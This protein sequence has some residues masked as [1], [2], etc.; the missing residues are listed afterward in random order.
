MGSTSASIDLRRTQKAKKRVRTFS[1]QQCHLGSALIRHF[2]SPQRTYEAHFSYDRMHSVPGVLNWPAHW[3]RQPMPDQAPKSGPR[4]ALA[5]PTLPS[6]TDKEYQVMHA[7]RSAWGLPLQGAGP[8]VLS[9]ASS[10]AGPFCAHLL[11]S[12]LP[13]C[14]PDSPAVF[15]THLACRHDPG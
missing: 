11:C 14:L 3:G 9:S 1:V 13:S 12:S 6:C 2:L 15:C 4:P 8:R 7:L 10:L 5:P